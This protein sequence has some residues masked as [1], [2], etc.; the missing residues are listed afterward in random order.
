MCFSKRYCDERLNRDSMARL[1]PSYCP[2]GVLN[3]LKAGLFRIPRPVCG[4]EHEFNMAAVIN[5]RHGLR[6]DEICVEYLLTAARDLGARRAY[7]RYSGGSRETEFERGRLILPGPGGL[8]INVYDDS[9][10]FEMSFGEFTSARKAIA[11]EKAMVPRLRAVIGRAEDMLREKYGEDPLLLVHLSGGDGHSTC[12]SLHLNIPW[13]DAVSHAAY[14]SQE[15]FPDLQETL[16]RQLLI[17]VTVAATGMPIEAGMASDPRSMTF[18][19]VTGC[20]TLEPHRPM[21]FQRLEARPSEGYEPGT[22]RNMGMVCNWGQ[23][24]V[25]NLLTLVLNQLETLRFHLVVGGFYQ[26]TRILAAGDNL[27]VLSH[28]LPLDMRRGAELHRRALDERH[29]FVAWLMKEVGEEVVGE[30]VPEVHE[31]LAWDDRVL[32][33]IEQND[34]ETIEGT[35]D[36]GKKLSLAEKV[37]RA[38]EG[39][40]EENLTA[41]RNVCFAFASPQELSPYHSYFVPKGLEQRVVSDEEI[42]DAGPDPLTRSYFFAAVIRKFWQDE[43]S[44]LDHVSWDWDRL[45][46]RWTAKRSG[47]WVPDLRCFEQII[48]LPSSIGHHQAAVE[49]VL[50]RIR[51]LDEL[52]EVFG[53]S[54][55]DHPSPVGSK[56][57]CDDGT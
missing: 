48:D 34:R 12:A 39:T 54:R 44:G 45:S 50:N 22:G 37:L 21:Q 42:R 2:R 1:E 28:Q 9:S 16:L 29:R 38:R 40:W 5:T 32:T 47:G 19:L 4:L 49:E 26:P 36:F 10:K 23:S 14:V 13:N 46:R 51:S 43:D 18:E 3:G 27:L 25:A 57:A 20:S 30:L 56:E 31:A 8:A 41:I 35:T 17:V 24:E 52:F 7:G 11:V 6:P 55:D 33:A 15:A 53:T